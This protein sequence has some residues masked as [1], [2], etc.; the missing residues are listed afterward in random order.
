MVLVAAVALVASIVSSHGSAGAAESSLH[1]WSTSDGQLILFQVK[2]DLMN[3]EGVLLDTTS[4]SPASAMA[5]LASKDADTIWT[6]IGPTETER[7]NAR[8]SGLGELAVVPVAINPLA[9]ATGS[10]PATAVT[11]SELCGALT[12]LVQ[13]SRRFVVRSDPSAANLALSDFCIR[14]EQ[15]MWAAYRSAIAANPSSYPEA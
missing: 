9:V 2:T 1:V 14:R 4:S 15:T 5:A 13:S 6:S 7:Q 11:S 12:S 3:S 10:G 8:N